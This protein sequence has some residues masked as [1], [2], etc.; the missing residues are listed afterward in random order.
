MPG[1]ALY[2]RYVPPK[3]SAS[4]VVKGTEN[5]QNAAPSTSSPLKRKREDAIEK[6]QKHRRPE[7]VNVQAGKNVEDGRERSEDHGLQQKSTDEAKLSSSLQTAVRSKEI[8]IEKSPERS[9][10]AQANDLTSPQLGEKD[11]KSKKKEKRKRLKMSQNEEEK[12]VEMDDSTARHAGVLSKFQ[13]A[14]QTSA[15]NAPADED[16]DMNGDED[17]QELHGPS[18][19]DI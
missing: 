6:K 3:A 2:A 8:E 14:L 11:G 18:H 15:K 7:N 13:N 17:E 4:A 1:P 10:V 5:N 9:A 19:T 12:D 16:V